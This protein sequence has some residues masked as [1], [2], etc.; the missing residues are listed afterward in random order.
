M[1]VLVNGQPGSVEVK[2]NIVTVTTTTGGSG[3]DAAPVEERFAASEVSQL[4]RSR[5]DDRVAKIVA[6]AGRPLLVQFS[7]L[8]DREALIAAVVATQA[9][10]RGADVGAN[11]GGGDAGAEQWVAGAICQAAVDVGALCPA[12]LR[13]IVDGECRRGVVQPFDALECLV[14]RA[15]FRLLP[16]TEAMEADVL[17]QIPVLAAI[18]EAHVMDE[19]TKRAFWEAVVRKYF[20]FSRTFLEEELDRLEP[21]EAAVEGEGEGDGLAAINGASLRALPKL[22]AAGAALEAAAGAEASADSEEARA[23]REGEA[24]AA[25]AEVWRQ[26]RFVALFRPTRRPCALAPPAAASPAPPPLGPSGP[27]PAVA[28]GGRKVARAAPREATHKDALETLRRFW[29]SSGATQR[30]AV[31][32]KYEGAHAGE[33]RRESF[34]EAACIARAKAWLD[35]AQ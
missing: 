26:D 4:M 33:T 11:A 24:A 31:L 17:R 9:A 8:A 29:R 19:D 12:E 28:V 30:R 21:T 32:A 6:D 18:F 2:G 14:D 1:R 22:T 27:V 23:V 35:A 3:A 25:G 34:L 15:T 7:S 10:E 5:K 13:A 20:C 16:L